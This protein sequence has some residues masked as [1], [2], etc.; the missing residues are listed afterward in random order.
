MQHGALKAGGAAR[1]VDEPAERTTVP[2]RH[3]D[4]EGLGDEPLLCDAEHGGEAPVDLAHVARRV[5]HHETLRS[6]LEEVPIAL[7]LRLDRHLGEDELVVLLTELLGRHL[8]LLDPGVDLFEQ[9]HFRGQR[10]CD[11]LVAEPLKGAARVLDLGFD[12]AGRHA[13]ESQ[14]TRRLSGR[15]GRAS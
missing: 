10:R 8:E 6:L 5:G 7:R 1:P 9:L 15:A 4:A 13:G 12:G 11:H 3:V 14:A 2:G